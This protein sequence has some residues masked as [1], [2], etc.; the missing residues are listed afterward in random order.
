MKPFINVHKG[1]VFGEGEQHSTEV[2]RFQVLEVLVDVIQEIL[3][4]IGSPP[5]VKE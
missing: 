5:E 1:T 2:Y 3:E 4:T